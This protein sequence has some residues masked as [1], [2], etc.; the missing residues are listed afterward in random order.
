MITYVR[1]PHPITAQQWFPGTVIAGVRE[2]ELYDEMV[3]LLDTPSGPLFL[4]SGDFLLCD[5]FNNYRVCST[6][7][8]HRLYERAD[9]D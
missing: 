7:T 4:H 1:R 6:D 8:F 5:E 9:A 2:V 3:G